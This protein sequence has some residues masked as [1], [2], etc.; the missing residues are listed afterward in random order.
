MAALNVDFMRALKSILEAWK[1][2]IASALQKSAAKGLIQS[3]SFDEIATFIVCSYEG[4]R[5]IGKIHQSKE[6]YQVYLSQLK[7]YLEQL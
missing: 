3:H 6:F 7:I 2:A 5:G 4:T 1:E